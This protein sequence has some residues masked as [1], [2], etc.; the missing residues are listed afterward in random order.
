[1]SHLACRIGYLYESDVQGITQYVDLSLF[2][3]NGKRIW[4]YYHNTWITGS[5]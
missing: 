5:K 3:F 2:L 4:H 1:M